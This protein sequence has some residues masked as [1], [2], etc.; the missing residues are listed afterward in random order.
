MRTLDWIVIVVYLAL[1]AGVG[2]SQ[3]RKQ[4]GTDDF[5]LGGRS[6]PWWAALMSL[7]ATE[8]S[9]ATFLG[10]PEQGYLRDL[11]YLQ[12]AFG[13]IAA[14]VVL[15][16]LFIGLFYNLGV[17]TVY[18]FL[19]RR[20]GGFTN[21]L[22]AGLFLVGRLFADGARLFIAAI[23]LK[24]ATGLDMLT[25][26]LVLGAVTLVYTFMGGISAVIWTDVVQ[27]CILVGGALVVIVSL[28]GQIPLTPAQVPWELLEHGKLRLFDF[29]SGAWTDPF[30]AAPAIIGGFFLTM[31]THGTDHDMVQRLLTCK[32][33]RESQR[34]MWVSGLAGLAVA[35]LFLAVGLLLYLYV[36]HLAPGDPMAATAGRL[37]ESGENAH[38]LLYYVVSQLP[39]GL[40]GL[41]LAAVM[42]AAMSSLSSALNA[43]AATVVS[44]FYRRF[45][46]QASNDHYLKV[47]RLATMVLGATIIGL[48]VL[49][50]KFWEAN[51]ETD[52]LSLALG[53]M[54][55]FYG[56]L[57]GIFLVGVL[58]TGRGN[59]FT[60]GLGVAAGIGAVLALARWTDLA[61]P[62]YT[63]AGTL[64]TT[65][66]SALGRR[67]IPSGENPSDTGTTTV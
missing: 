24:V 26:I 22:A 32:N 6:V 27:G 46:P 20:F 50:L 25:S 11:T 37:A 4:H 61:W 38:L 12:F 15:A 42:A 30:H 39:A 5:F 23:T 56:A 14:R 17:T 43:T 1:V 33:S 2:I 3:A 28:L 18:G 9:A 34:S 65:A 64:V 48:A 60:N 63:V 59:S 51:P 66:I 57:L 52:L 29:G 45:V 49:V 31:A 13:S 10:A 41:V 44:D 62:W 35:C 8:V 19:T 58:T 55:F 53:I 47:S 7:V 16:T 21:A 54:T 67:G 40:T 36:K